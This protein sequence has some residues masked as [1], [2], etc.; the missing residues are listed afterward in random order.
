MHGGCCP[1]SVPLSSCPPA[2]A[3]CSKNQP[4][5]A[6]VPMLVQ[7]WPFGIYPAQ[8]G[9]PHCVIILPVLGIALLDSPLGGCR[10]LYTW[11]VILSLGSLTTV[12][13][14]E[15]TQVRRVTLA[16]SLLPFTSSAAHSCACH[17]AGHMLLSPLPNLC[18]ILPPVHHL[19]TRS[20]PAPIAAYCFT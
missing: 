19:S 7:Q 20:L 1:K 3:S 13:V 17:H 10:N 8:P 2:E 6:C 15:S 18:G 12:R 14:P 11:C 16:L 5:P 9:S 4:A